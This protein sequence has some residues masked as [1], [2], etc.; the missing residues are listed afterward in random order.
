M[1]RCAIIALFFLCAANSFAQ[2]I[3][4]NESKYYKIT[5]VPVPDSIMLE[6]GGLAFTGDDKLGVATR[7]GE[8]WVID[9]PYRKKSQTPR[10]SLFASGLHEPLWLAHKKGAFYTTQ[11][12][13]LTKISDSNGDG[14]ADLFQTIYSW[15]ISGNYHEYSYGPL[16]LPNGEMLVTLN[17]S[18]VGR[19]ES[20]TKWRGWMLKI[21][22]DGKMTPFATGMRSPAAFGLNASGDIFVAENQG[23]WIGSGRITHLKAGDFAGH[24]A[25][26]KWSAEPGSPI[27]LKRSSFADSIGIMYDYAQGK[28]HLKVPSIWF[29]HTV[30]GISTSAI[31]SMDSDEAGPFKDQLLVGDQ[32]HSKIM[33][34]FLEKVN[35]QYQGACFPFRE[36]FASGILRMAWGS[37]HSLFV[38]MTSRG[39]ASTGKDLFGLQRLI[40][41]KQFPLEIKAM[42]ITTT[43]FELEFTKPVNKIIASATENYS[44]TGFTYSYHKKYGSPVINSGACNVSQA[45][46]SED[47]N[48]VK[49]TVNGLRAGY[50]HEL[51]IAN[52]ATQEGEK[53]LHPEAYYTVNAFPEGT[54]HAHHNMAHTQALPTA[55]GCGNDP[56]KSVHEQ[57]AEWKTG[58]E[59]TINMGTKPGLKFDKEILE[60]KAGSKVKLVFNNNDDMLHNLVV[61]APGKGEEVGQNAMDMGL[62]GTNAGYIPDS[63]SVL[64]H[65]CLIQPETSQTIFFTAPKPGDYPFICSFPGHSFVMKGVMKVR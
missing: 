39:W 7:R 54:D 11:R 40:F 24:P 10:Y 21:T 37:D 61:T 56:S 47:G 33:R 2:H 64:F 58:A 14:L 59:I 35:G 31:V 49:L 51:K 44:I 46:V 30:M 15:P 13:E 4:E 17:L 62:N 18:W 20:L 19:G 5:T 55:A 8:I 3:L 52:V 57:P 48:K 23:D 1:V 36:G 43:G 34:A 60:L 50:I 28:P 22:E 32:G 41:P 27:D 65:T 6:V 25:G 12:S 29:P 38:G 16:I 63:K 53:L 42:R 26:L 9:D 45:E